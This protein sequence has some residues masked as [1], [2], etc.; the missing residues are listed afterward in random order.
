MLDRSIMEW[1]PA[2]LKL[3]KKLMETQRG[4]W[5]SVSKK[6]QDKYSNLTLTNLCRFKT[7][8]EYIEYRA[9]TKD[10]IIYLKFY[11]HTLAAGM[12]ETDIG[13]QCYAIVL[14]GYTFLDKDTTTPTTQQIIDFMRWKVSEDQIIEFYDY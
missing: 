1:T 12:H 11:G 4:E 14:G 3:Q 13:A 2:F 9:E 7:D 8:N 10:K 5:V 6:I